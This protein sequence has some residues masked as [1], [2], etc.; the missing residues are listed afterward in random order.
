MPDAVKVK[1][2][3]VNCRFYSWSKCWCCLLS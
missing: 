3:F 1:S 2:D